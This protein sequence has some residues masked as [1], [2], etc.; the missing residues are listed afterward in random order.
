MIDPNYRSGKIFDL[1]ESERKAQPPDTAV[2]SG[3]IYDR[4]DTPEGRLP[5]GFTVRWVDG[6]LRWVKTE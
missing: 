2:R 1:P 3:R 5:R 6:Y 4:K